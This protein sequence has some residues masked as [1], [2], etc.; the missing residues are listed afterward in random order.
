[1]GT[2][3]TRVATVWL[4]YHLTQ[5][6]LLLGLLSFANQLP[7]FVLVPFAGIL[8]DR[9]NHGQTLIITQALSMLQS[10]ALAVLAIT[11]IIRFWHIIKFVLHFKSNLEVILSDNSQ[12]LC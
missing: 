2:W 7:S 4:T 10:L 1:M 12:L 8:V 11:G 9:W 6:P 3:I 5:S